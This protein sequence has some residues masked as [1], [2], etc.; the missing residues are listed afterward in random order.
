MVVEGAGERRRVAVE[1]TGQ[2]R[3]GGQAGRGEGLVDAVAGERV[4]E[5]GGVADEQHA[6]V[7][8]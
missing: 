6:S 2:D 7:R 1:V 8:R 5:A 4:D 3:L